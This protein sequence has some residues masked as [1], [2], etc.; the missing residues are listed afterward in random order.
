MTARAC[1]KSSL[2]SSSSSPLPSSLA[3]LSQ[4][5]AAPRCRGARPLSRSVRLVF[6]ARA[7]TVSRRSRPSSARRLWRTKAK[8]KGENV[9]GRSCQSSS[10]LVLFR[11]FLYFIARGELF[12]FSLFPSRPFRSRSDL[13]VFLLDPSLRLLA[14]SSLALVCHFAF[15]RCTPRQRLSFDSFTRSL[16]SRLP[17]H[18]PVTFG[19]E[20]RVQA[21]DSEPLV[22]SIL[23]RQSQ[24]SDTN[25][26]HPRTA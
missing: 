10:S 3:R 24:R 2:P 22:R 26:H 4:S 11:F 25:G 9:T 21:T 20:R 6:I 14:R 16:D 19:F 23:P 12:A 7:V 17:P 5:R 13:A 18:A 8:L 15:A 1:S